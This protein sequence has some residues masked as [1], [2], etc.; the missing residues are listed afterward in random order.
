[1]PNVPQLFMASCQSF[2]STRIL[3]WHYRHLLIYNYVCEDDTRFKTFNQLEDYRE[4]FAFQYS[5]L[6]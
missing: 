4:A 5:I 6:L 2:E 1:M 3:L